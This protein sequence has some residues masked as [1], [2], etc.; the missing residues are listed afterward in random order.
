MAGQ[1]NQRGGSKE[2]ILAVTVDTSDDISVIKPPSVLQGCNR[3]AT[4]LNL[5][6]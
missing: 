3:S 6:V 5:D 2:I 4:S 1:I